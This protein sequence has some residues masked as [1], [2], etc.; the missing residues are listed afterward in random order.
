MD[1][2]NPLPTNDSK[3]F[4][5]E[6]EIYGLDK[7]ISIEHVHIIHDIILKQ[8]ASSYERYKPLLLFLE[9]TKFLNKVI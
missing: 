3:K 6:D 1:D 2:S 5:L 9:D 4:E 8:F 7:A